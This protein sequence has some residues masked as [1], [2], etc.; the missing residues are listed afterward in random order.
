[1]RLLTN[2]RPVL[3]VLVSLIVFG[4]PTTSL[5]AET[6][7]TADRVYVSF[8]DM[9]EGV[10]SFGAAVVG[11]TLYTYGGHRGRAHEYAVEYQSDQF[12]R[13]KL[14]AGAEWEE[15]PSGPRLQ[16]LALLAHGG[17]LYRI[18]GFTT[19]NHKGEDEDL[20]SVADVA[21]FDPS[22]NEWEALP[23]LPTPRSSLDGVVL[24]DRIYVVGGWQLRGKDDEPQWHQS[25]Y[26]LDLSRAELA[27]EELPQPPFQRRA[28]S[29]GVLDGKVYAIGGIMPDGDIS[30]DVDVYDPQSGEW[31]KAATL[32]GEGVEGFGTSAFAANGKL[33]VSNV[34]AKVF[35]LATGQEAW[36]EVG[37]LKEKR[38][39]HRMVTTADEQLLVVGGAEWM[40]GKANTVYTVPVAAHDE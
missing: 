10:T 19:H 25:A 1:M 34:A 8:T 21:R 33:Y 23:S 15:L 37:Q 18:G 36:E 17:K 39:F 22:K 5:V 28:L 27:W 7:A 4:F 40:K 30:M 29:V 6:P 11:D 38:L 35:C 13:L 32:P 2:A 31:S 20:R 9:P 24:G 26:V 16:G 14:V 3:G 12:R